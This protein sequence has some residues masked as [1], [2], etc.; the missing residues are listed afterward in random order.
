MKSIRKYFVISCFIAIIFGTLQHFAFDLTNNNI[1]IGLI[2]PV[3]ESV[4]EHLKL[5]FLPLT[6]FA[7]ITKIVL[8]Q[9]N[10]MIA[11]TI[12]TIISCVLILTIHYGFLLFNIESTAIDIIAYILSM[13]LGF[14]IMYIFYSNPPLLEKYE[15]LGY[16]LIVIMFVI[17][18]IFT[19][20]P[21]KTPLFLDNTLNIYGVY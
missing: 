4:W 19:L 14:Y 9:K 16:T 8:K 3:N 11:T 7:I 1:L 10:I 13:F 15:I 21:P 12:A 20:H 2:S 17:F 6:I 5:I 18:G